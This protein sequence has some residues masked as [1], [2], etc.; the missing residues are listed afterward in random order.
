[1]AGLTLLAVTIYLYRK[2]KPILYTLLPMLLV[3]T[4]TVSGMFIG[5]SKA[6]SNAQWSVAVV[7]SIIL[8]LALWVLVEAVLAVVTIRGERKA[9]AAQLSPDG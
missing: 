9:E 7:G 6:I 8:I 2:R 3:L 4:A 1:M 5:V